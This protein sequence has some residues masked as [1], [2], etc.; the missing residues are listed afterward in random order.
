MISGI[1]AFVVQLILLVHILRY[2]QFDTDLLS[3]KKSCP[4]QTS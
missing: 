1:E 4:C 2:L 3:V